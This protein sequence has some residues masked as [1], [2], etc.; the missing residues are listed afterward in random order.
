MG[1]D[2]KEAPKTSTKVRHLDASS[3]AHSYA[4]KHKDR[5]LHR[6]PDV[7]DSLLQVTRPVLRAKTII[8]GLFS[9]GSPDTALVA[10]VGDELFG[11]PCCR[12]PIN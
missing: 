6:L 8:S 2:S 11:A 12:C 4:A 1:A 9:Q 10:A 7:L 5:S 3:R